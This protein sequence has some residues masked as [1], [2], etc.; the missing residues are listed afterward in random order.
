V[1]GGNGKVGQAA[2]QIATAAGARIFGV[3][4]TY[5]PYRGHA[6]GEVT[7]LAASDGDVAERARDETAGRRADIVFNTVG[8]P[9]FEAANRA[10]AIRGRQI[11]IST[12]ERSV[13]ID[14]FAF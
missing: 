4:R 12:I 11:L 2:I 8:S 13:P 3:T 1:L 6:A 5:E 9:Y 14:I 10:V 7:M